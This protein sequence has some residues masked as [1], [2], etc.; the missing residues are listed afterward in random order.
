MII[1]D[2]KAVAEKATYE[3]PTTLAVGMKWVIVNGK[4]AV[5][6]GKFSG[7]L[8]GRALRKNAEERT[9]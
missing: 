7:A 9:P 3:T 4:L 5:E 1:F 8:A 2:E 6:D